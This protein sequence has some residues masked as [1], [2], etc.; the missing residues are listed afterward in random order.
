MNRKVSEQIKPETWME[1][2]MTSCPTVQCMPREGRCFGKDNN[3]RKITGS[4]KRVRLNLRWTDC[5]ISHRR[6]STGTVCH[7][8]LWPSL[9]QKVARGWSQLKGTRHIE[10]TLCPF[11]HSVSGCFC[12][13]IVAL[14]SCNRDHLTQETPKHLHLPGPL[15]KNSANVLEDP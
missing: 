10:N 2:K 3:L 5:T 4:R 1:A 9:I 15:L 11:V 14:I 12:S 6:E 7:R 13:M 8:A